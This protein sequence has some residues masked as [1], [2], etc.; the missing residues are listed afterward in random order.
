MFSR[1]FR[2]ILPVMSCCAAACASPRA[3]AE[4]RSV[5]EHPPPASTPLVAPVTSSGEP[6]TDEDRENGVEWRFHVGSTIHAAPAVATDG[7]VY[8]GTGDGYVIAVSDVG[9]LRWSFT[10]EGAVAWSP[11]V[12]VVDHVIVATLARHLYSIAPSGQIAWQREPPAHVSTELR[13]A[14]RSSFVFGASDGALWAYSI[15]STALWHVE[16][17]VVL[18]APPAVRG[19]RI[20]LA[21]QDGTLLLLDGAERRSAVHFEGSPHAAPAIAEDGTIYA[22]FGDTLVHVDARGAVLS[23]QRGIDTFAVSDQGLLE[24]D[25]RGDLVQCSHDFA[26]RSRTP[27]PSRPS[28]P[29]LLV[30]SSIYVPADDGTLLVVRPGTAPVAVRI[31]RAS[32]HEPVVDAPRHR[33]VVAEGS[34]TV[35]AVRIAE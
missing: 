32:L 25:T 13:L 10:V 34:G 22:L 31:G 27:L 15:H 6:S 2:Q 17:H 28:A 18:G 11:L 35:A 1:L 14:P 7:T 3:Q 4:V 33:I 24:V 8:V 26:E 20:V 16:T 21:A 23:V 29:P 9:S 5:P 12:D 19:N 30:G